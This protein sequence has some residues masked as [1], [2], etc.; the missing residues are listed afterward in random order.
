[1]KPNVLNEPFLNKSTLIKTNSPLSS[2]V[3]L[4]AVIMMSLMTPEEPHTAMIR[5]LEAAFIR[6]LSYTVV[7]AA[8]S[9]NGIWEM[10]SFWIPPMYL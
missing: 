1:M 3:V 8:S 6:R 9:L 5:D 2:S 4:L 7:L 10:L